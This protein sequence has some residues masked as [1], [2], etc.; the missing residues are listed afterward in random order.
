MVPEVLAKTLMLL[1]LHLRFALI[2]G[3]CCDFLFDG[4]ATHH[5]IKKSWCSE[6]DPMVNAVSLVCLPKMDD[7]EAEIARSIFSYMTLA[8][9]Y[10]TPIKIIGQENE[11]IWQ[12]TEMCFIN[13]WLRI[14]ILTY[15]IAV[16]RRLSCNTSLDLCHIALCRPYWSMWN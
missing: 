4:D 15:M 6:S 13:S 11:I 10:R 8:L 3:S 5:I 12:S 2:N 7:F 1:P 9:N 16:L 14:S